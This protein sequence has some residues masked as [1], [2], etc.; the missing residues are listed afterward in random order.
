MNLGLF[1]S[2]DIPANIGLPWHIKFGDGIGFADINDYEIKRD[3]YDFFFLSSR[4]DKYELVDISFDD[5]QVY[6]TTEDAEFAV[7][8]TSA[9]FP[10]LSKVIPQASTTRIAVARKTLVDAVDR[11][12]VMVKDAGWMVA[13]DVTPGDTLNI[14]AFAPDIGEA[15]EAISADIKGDP[16]RIVPNSRYLLDGLKAIDSDEVLMLM[17]GSQSAVVVTKEGFDTFKYV[18][19]P[20][21]M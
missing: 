12:S 17:N 11:A 5:A 6:F 1:T 14:S 21:N 9:R 13:L 2:D 7:R 8:R 15:S 20:I 3:E 10:E 16:V 4:D 19:M 18:L